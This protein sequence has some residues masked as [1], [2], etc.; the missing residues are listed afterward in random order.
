VF[1]IITATTASSDKG[2]TV[3]FNYNSTEPY[4]YSIVD[5]TGRVI[6]AKGNNSAEPGAN[7]IDIPA[8]LS[9]GVYQIILQNSSKVVSKKFFY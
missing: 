4:N 8:S 5:M 9:K 3:V 7:V 1:D 6:V 2:V